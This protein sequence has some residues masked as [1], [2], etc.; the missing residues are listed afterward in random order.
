MKKR[1]QEL[2]RA[3]AKNPTEELKQEL[4]NILEENKKLFKEILK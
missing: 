2:K 1:I 4:R 3:I